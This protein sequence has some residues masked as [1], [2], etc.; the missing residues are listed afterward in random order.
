VTTEIELLK[1]ELAELKQTVADLINPPK[2]APYQ[3]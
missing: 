1:A 3:G 2:P